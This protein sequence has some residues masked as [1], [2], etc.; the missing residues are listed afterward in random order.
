MQRHP[1]FSRSEVQTQEVCV[2]I[3]AG[4]HLL[5]QL[6]SLILVISFD[7]DDPDDHEITDVLFHPYVIGSGYQKPV[8]MKPSTIYEA[9]RE[10]A[11]EQCSDAIYAAIRDEG[12]MSWHTPRSIEDAQRIG[13]G[14]WVQS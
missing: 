7:Q 5:T 8:S 13:I 10:A 3:F 6:E 1:Y 12:G 2:D 14:E 11:A 4:P 9:I